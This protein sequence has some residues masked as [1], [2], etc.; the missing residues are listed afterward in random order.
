M[1]NPL[2]KSRRKRRKASQA[3][4]HRKQPAKTTVPVETIEKIIHLHDIEH[5]GFRKAAAELGMTKDHAYRLYKE[6]AATFQKTKTKNVQPKPSAN[7]A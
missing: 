5:K 6:H 3:S 4:Q 2:G 7:S 1:G